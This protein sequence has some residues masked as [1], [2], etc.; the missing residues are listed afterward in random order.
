MTIRLNKDRLV[1]MMEEQ[2]EIGGT[3]AGGL[4]RLALTD[5]DRAARDWFR[6]RMEEAGLE[7][8]IDRIGNMFG[9]R[10]GTDPDA[11]PVLLGSHL[12]SQ[13][14]GGIYDGPLGLLAALEFVLTLEE[15]DLETDHP[16]EIVNWT[17]EEGARFQ[18]PMMA[19]EVWAGKLELEDVYRETD[20][21]GVTLESELERI[22]YKGEEPC[23]PHED[24]EVYLELHIEQGPKLEDGGFDVGVV[25]GIVGLTWTETTFY[26]TANHTGPTPIDYREDA[27]VPAGELITEIRRVA[28]QLGPEARGTVG[29]IEY[30]TQAISVVPDE[31]SV[32][33]EIVHPDDA[34]VQEGYER[35]LAEVEHVAS[36]EGVEHQSRELSRFE[37]V[38][39][40]ERCMEAFEDAAESLGYDYTRLFGGAG[41]NASSLP[42]VCDTGM[43]FAVSED[44]LSHTE[45]E[46]TSWD[47]CYSAANTLAN[48]ALR[49]AT[50]D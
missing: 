8:R 49:I 31:V 50:D 16:I 11:A 36:R 41:H 1:Q 6:E 20:E 24:Y 4:N 25:T 46:F 2:S 5:S 37:S 18:P 21:D 26:G 14:D 22:G 23:R 45:A 30:D 13:P 34:V 35:M 9:R 40:D 15:E 38:R 42:S 43:V 47:D 29:K 17:N 10:E 28:Q 44:G 12:D 33:W 39:F 7:I 27:L 48:A 32:V 3:E 19:S